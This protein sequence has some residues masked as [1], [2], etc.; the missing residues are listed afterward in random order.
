M[1]RCKVRKAQLIARYD[2][3]RWVELGVEPSDPPVS[4]LE[5][6]CDRPQP[7]ARFT[8]SNLINH[9]DLTREEVP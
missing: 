2:R 8:K 1:I 7:P 3:V 5:A 9:Q 6:R 4:E